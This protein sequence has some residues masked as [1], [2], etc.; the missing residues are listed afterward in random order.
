MLGE[1][2]VMSERT[3]TTGNADIKSRTAVESASNFVGSIPGGARPAE[4]RV[5]WG[6]TNPNP[7]PNPT[8]TLP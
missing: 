5:S 4:D 1:R 7:N 6:N 3:M 2:V 8:L